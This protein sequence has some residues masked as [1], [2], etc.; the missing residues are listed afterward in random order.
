[1]SQLAYEDIVLEAPRIRES[2]VQALQWERSW[3]ATGESEQTSFH[4]VGNLELWEQ[5]WLAGKLLSQRVD[6]V[7]IHMRIAN[8]MHEVAAFEARDVGEEAS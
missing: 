8:D 3:R 1:M 2:S 7:V 5:E 6:M 4:R